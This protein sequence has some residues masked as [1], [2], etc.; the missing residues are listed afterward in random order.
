MIAFDLLER[1][2][3]SS[4]FGCPVPGKSTSSNR[5]VNPTGLHDD[6]EVPIG[7]VRKTS[8]FV[9]CAA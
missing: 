8:N 9:L 6:D 7:A 2:L 5:M 4:C 3:E 1:S